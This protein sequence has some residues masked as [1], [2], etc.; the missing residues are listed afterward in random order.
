[1]GATV[2]EKRGEKSARQD[3]R[4]RPRSGRDEEAALAVGSWL[5]RRMG[6]ERR[7]Q[8]LEGSAPEARCGARGPVPSG[9]GPPWQYAAFYA[10][11]AIVSR[12]RKMTSEITWAREEDQQP[13]VQVEG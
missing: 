11:S 3:R 2:E 4:V 10:G 7:R 13:L 5:A 9:S 8:L 6:W 1:M 12:P